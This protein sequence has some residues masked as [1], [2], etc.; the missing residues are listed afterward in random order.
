MLSMQ[1]VSL[2]FFGVCVCDIPSGFVYAVT[3]NLFAVA[4]RNSPALKL[5]KS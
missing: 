4:I 2:A 1:M 3:R 5:G